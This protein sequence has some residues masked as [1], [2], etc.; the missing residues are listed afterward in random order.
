MEAAGEMGASHFI[1][2]G[3]GERGLY[4]ASLEMFQSPFR[5]SQPI[6]S[7]LPSGRFEK[8]ESSS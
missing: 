5:P 8:T 6:R 1:L 7:L 4:V 2:I 3:Y